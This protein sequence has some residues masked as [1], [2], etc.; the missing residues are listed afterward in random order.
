MSMMVPNAD[1][2]LPIFVISPG[3]QPNLV[4]SPCP[5]CDAGE[6]IPRFQL[7]ASLLQLVV[8][9]DCGLGRLWPPP[10]SEVIASFYSQK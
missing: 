8:C 2:D 7:D 3:S 4:V 9:P 6:A 10:T 1:Y 5:V